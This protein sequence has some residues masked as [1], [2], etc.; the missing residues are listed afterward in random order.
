MEI[1]FA[2]DAGV[3]CVATTGPDGGSNLGSGFGGKVNGVATSWDGG[4]TVETSVDA[5][6]TWVTRERDD[7][8]AKTHNLDANYFPLVS[9]NADL[10]VDY[11]SSAPQKA[12]LTAS[13]AS[14]SGLGTWSFH[15]AV[16][17]SATPTSEILT[18][19]TTTNGVR[20]ANS[21]V[22]SGQHLD[23]P[24]IGLGIGGQVVPLSGQG[25][26]DATSLAFHPGHHTSAKKL[27]EVR[28]S[29]T[30]PVQFSGAVTELGQ[31]CGG[32]DVWVYAG[33]SLVASTTALNTD[34]AW[35]F[36]NSTSGVIRVFVGPGSA[37][38]CDHSQ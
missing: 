4:L 22:R 25:A 19:S 28:F 5:G 30:G 38:S 12:G 3:A 10:R 9:P 34:A 15:A 8:A 18:Y 33:S 20:A 35:S 24:A 7:D 17:Q 13:F 31:H 36:A 6:F 32:V 11:E 27:L 1:R 21:F 37:Y 23:L 14:P 26:A 16:S 2:S 29:P